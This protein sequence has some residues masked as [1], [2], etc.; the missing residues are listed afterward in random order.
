VIRY[1][2][3]GKHALGECIVSRYI[4]GVTRQNMRCISHSRTAPHSLPHR[5]ERPQ[6][7]LGPH[8]N[9]PP[10]RRYVNRR[11]C[12]SAL[13]GEQG[14]GPALIKGWRVGVVLSGPQG[15]EGGSAIVASVT[16]GKDVI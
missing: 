14:R 2:S 10:D 15:M 11:P 7:R 3:G 13:S 1:I 16:Y 4:S 9:M 6:Y 12:L 8:A 5:S